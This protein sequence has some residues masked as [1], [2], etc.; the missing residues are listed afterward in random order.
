MCASWHERPSKNEKC[1]KCLKHH[2]R[3]W[4]ELQLH[5]A[6]YSYHLAPD[7][8]GTGQ[9]SRHLCKFSVP[10][11]K[12]NTLGSL[13]SVF[14][15]Q[16][17]PSICSYIHYI[18]YIYILYYIYTYYIYILLYI[19]IYYI[20]SHI[21]ESSPGPRTAPSPAPPLGAMEVEGWP[22]WCPGTVRRAKTGGRCGENGGLTW[23][24]CD[25]TIFECW[26]LEFIGWF[27]ERFIE[28][29]IEMFIAN[30][31]HVELWHR[32]VWVWDTAVNP[33]AYHRKKS[34][35]QQLINQLDV[36]ETLR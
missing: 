31:M 30:P 20:S 3:L 9:H 13:K 25:E 32:V 14:T 15:L 28:R 24:N 35:H 2:G 10:A 11:M 16:M 36:G 18:L 29:F 12:P 6:S 7:N 1:Q 26:F 8:T 4:V 17:I 27:I 34:G 33:L 21:Q 23:L 5:I 19:Y 22:R